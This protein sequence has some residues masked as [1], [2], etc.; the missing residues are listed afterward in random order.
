MLQDGREPHMEVA[1]EPIIR[2]QFF[3]HLLGG[4]GTQGVI[5][6]LGAEV[7]LEPHE[8]LLGAVVVDAARPVVAHE[9]IVVTG[10]LC[11]AEE[12]SYTAAGSVIY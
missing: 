1:R 2:S 9:H 5:L 6:Y 8:P 10:E 3:Q 12:L 7:L 11:R 4:P